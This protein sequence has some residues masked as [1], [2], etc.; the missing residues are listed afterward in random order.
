MV[1]YFRVD[2]LPLTPFVGD[3]D[4]NGDGGGSGDNHDVGLFKIVMWSTISCFLLRSEYIRWYCT[5]NS[6][7][8]AL[9]TPYWHTVF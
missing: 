8:I 6:I 3:D 7:P 2:V 4:G 5:I 1:L 9:H